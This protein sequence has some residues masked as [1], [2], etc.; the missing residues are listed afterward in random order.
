[1][2]GLVYSLVA[3][4]AL[5]IGAAA[6][7]GFTFSLIEAVLSAVVFGCVAVVGLERNL[8]RRAEN[9]L[10]KAVEELSRLLSTDAQAGAVLSQRLNAVIEQNSSGRLESIEADIS[11]LGT[12]VRQ[13]AEAVA[14]LDEQR[15]Q[16]PPAP[17]IVEAQA[18]APAA[19]PVEMLPEPVIP[20]EMLRQALAE[21]RLVH[22]IEPIVQLPQR[23]PVAYDLVPRLL[24]EDGDIADREDFMPRRG[25]ETVVRRIE[26]MALDEAVTIVRR[27]RT[28][29]QPISVA[30]PM[31][32]ASL[33]DIPSIEQMLV[34]LDANRVVAQAIALAISEDDWRAFSPAERAALTSL[35]KKGVVV[36]L[37]R[38]RSLRWDFAALAGDGVRSLRFDAARFLADPQAF[39]DFHPSDIAAYVKRFEI[40]L[41]ATGIRTEQQIISFLED[42][43]LLVQGPHIAGP[44]PVRPDLV[45]EQPA[46]PALRR[47]EL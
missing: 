44:G 36:S 11:V 32:R 7:F 39:T 19:P 33:D 45:V 40:D 41:I 21:N 22:H 30:V 15:K 12:V 20:L 46:R 5:A 34:A 23:R 38:V 17:A 9:R 42:G 29:G 8:R 10:E 4:S 2:Q 6:Y 25:G 31:T 26:R 14:E 18:V 35:V 3:L 27:A 1:M 37:T 13:V 16:A 28:A 24:L 43:V 47:V